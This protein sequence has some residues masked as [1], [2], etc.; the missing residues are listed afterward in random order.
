MNL[1]VWSVLKS[2]TLFLGESETFADDM[3]IIMAHLS[4]FSSPGALWIFLL[5]SLQTKL[6][7][8]V[9]LTRAQI[10]SLLTHTLC[11]SLLKF[12][13]FVNFHNSLYDAV[14]FQQYHKAVKI[15]H[16]FTWKRP[17]PGLC[18]KWVNPGV[19]QVYRGRVMGVWLRDY[20]FLCSLPFLLS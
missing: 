19:P 1:L 6:F 4:C 15:F 20:G 14:S 16:S 12:K 9:Y 7:T 2:L 18:G 8:H 5:L 3:V 10:F 17:M 11:L 13:L